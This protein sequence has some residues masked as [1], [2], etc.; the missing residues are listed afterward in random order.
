MIIVLKPGMDPHQ[1][2]DIEEHVK[3]AGGSPVLIEGKERCVV[4][5]IGLSKLDPKIFEILP[6]VAQVMRVGKPYKLA[7]REVK[8]ENT[9]V[10]LDGL[11]IGGPQVMV[12]AGP[13]AVENREMLLETAQQLSHMG[14]TVLR[15]GAFK[16]R[17]NPYSFQGLGEEGL[18]YLAE[19]REATGMKV[20]T[21]V[22][23][24]GKVEVVA[25]YSDILQIGAR[26]MQNF[27]LL[28]ACSEVKN[29]VL[30]K[31]GISAT[32]DEW[33]Q[34]AEYIL[35]KNPRVI[36]CERGI[37]TFE[38]A[39]RNTLDLNAIPVLRERTHLPIIV[40]PSHGTGVR[41]YVGP[42]A[43]AA[44]AAGADGVMIEV[45]PRPEEALSDGPQSLTPEML[46]H[47]LRD[48][49]V[50]APVVGRQ[51]GLS[52]KHPAPVEIQAKSDAVAF[53]G[54]AGAFS[55]KALVAYF[56]E[57]VETLSCPDFRDVFEKVEDGECPYGIIPLENSLAGSVHPNF[58]HLL[59]Y[60]ISIVGELKLRVVHNL[61][62]H[63]GTHVKDLR[64]VYAHP[65][66]AAQC[67]RFLRNHA[68]WSVFQVYDTAGSVKMIRDE[69]ILDGA[70]IASV[71]AAEEFGLE[72]L[73]QGIENDPQNYTRFIVISKEPVSN[74]QANKV[75]LAYQT[76]DD[77]GALLRTLE[78]F[79]ERKINLSKLESCPIAGKP[80]E[81]LFYVD[82]AGNLEDAAV[83]EALAELK[84][85]TTSLK[86]LGSYPAA[87]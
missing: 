40:D 23:S 72:V 49:E 16:P 2:K 39:T 37:R 15:G 22:M 52:R 11:G 7:S 76:K 46:E 54:E 48:L 65:Q 3:N 77:S 66:A 57:K 30:L 84:E 34:A 8:P 14:V 47:L 67:E 71:E 6:G 86:V 28:R 1:V 4:A 17:T 45:H 69:K 85:A 10:D 87:S 21:E 81:Y 9:V 63:A 62:A 50:I 82:L 26:N 59:E 25:K 42:M 58:H 68:D 18:K 33:L 12:M 64:R 31:R 19:A 35:A 51:L 75:S 29:P 61:I 79:A 78:I 24:A 43:L 53:Q 20:I 32:I 36:L 70:A 60:N 73:V 41:S 55:E 5:V 27:D 74:P 56:G 80:W 83:Q 38:T 44:V 13:C